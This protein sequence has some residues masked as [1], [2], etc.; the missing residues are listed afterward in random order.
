MNESKNNP[1]LTVREEA[2]Q[3][4]VYKNSPVAENYTE[5]KTAESYLKV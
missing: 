1:D 4:A 5:V 2:G 3:D